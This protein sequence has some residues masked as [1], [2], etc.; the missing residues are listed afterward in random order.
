MWSNALAII[1]IFPRGNT[2]TRVT[3]MRNGKV[4]SIKSGGREEEEIGNTSIHFSI[5]KTAGEQSILLAVYW[6]SRRPDQVLFFTLKKK[7]WRDGDYC[8]SDTELALCPLSKLSTASVHSGGGWEKRRE[9]STAHHFWSMSERERGVQGVNGHRKLK[10][11]EY[12]FVPMRD[13]KSL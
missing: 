4:N 6:R 1:D 2:W 3:R 11:R 8:S 12:T 10:S 7:V 13:E 5:H 9:E